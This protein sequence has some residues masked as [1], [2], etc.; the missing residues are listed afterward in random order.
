MA[1]KTQKHEYVTTKSLMGTV[2]DLAWNFGFTMEDI[3]KANM[4]KTQ[5]RLL[6]NK[7]KGQGDER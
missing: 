1:A 2:S 4:Q 5:D 6:R 7:I 3:M